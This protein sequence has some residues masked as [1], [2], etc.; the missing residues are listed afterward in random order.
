MA[1][2]KW[3]T[4]LFCTVYPPRAPVTPLAVRYYSTEL[5][6]DMEEEVIAHV[7]Y[8][9]QSHKCVVYTLAQTRAHLTN[10]L[11]NIFQNACRKFIPLS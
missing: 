7:K 9:V 2:D 5:A 4:V 8:I 6:P 10:Y 11:I 3:C 1:L